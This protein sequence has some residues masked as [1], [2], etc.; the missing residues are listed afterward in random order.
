MSNLL[1][2]IVPFKKLLSNSTETITLSDSPSTPILTL[3]QDRVYHIPDFQREIRWSIE[4]TA[5]LIDDITTSPKYLGN[6]ILTQHPNNTYSIIDGQQRL[7]ILA[8]CRACCNNKPF[9]Q[10]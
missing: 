7:T 2:I 9:Q 8:I 4:N 10:P 1:G 6:I 5:L 3:E